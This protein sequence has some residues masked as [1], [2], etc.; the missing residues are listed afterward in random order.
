M[1]Q[2][3]DIIAISK[4]VSPEFIDSE[5]ITSLSGDDVEQN[6]QDTISIYDEVV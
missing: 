6:K 2:L 3:K 1:Q 4:G 5:L